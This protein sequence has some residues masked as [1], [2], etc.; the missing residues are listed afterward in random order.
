MDILRKFMKNLKLNKYL[1][2]EKPFSTAYPDLYREVLTG[3]G[4]S[5]L[6]KLYLYIHEIPVPTCPACGS[7][8]K[9]VG[10]WKGYNRFCGAGCSNKFNAAQVATTKLRKYG[11][12]GYNNPEQARKTCLE[13]YGENYETRRRPGP[14]PEERKTRLAATWANKTEEEKKA[15]Q[16]KR[17]RTTRTRYGTDNIMHIPEV[18]TKAQRT[19][20]DR[21]GSPGQY[22]R[23]RSKEGI[24]RKTRETYPEFIGY[25]GTDWICR[26]PHPD[27]DKCTERTYITNPGVHRDRL[28]NQS[29]LCTH[30]QP[31]GTFVEGTAP[32]LFVREI[33]DR[34]G[35][36]HE[37]NRYDLI[38]PLSLDIYMPDH[39][40]AIECNGIYWHS[41]IFKGSKDHYRKWLKCKESDIRLITIWEDWIKR[42]PEIV[43]SL[44]LNRL[45]RTGTSIGARQA[46]VVK[47]DSSTAGAFLEANHIQGATP[48]SVR[49]GLEYK[50][51]LVSLMCFSGRG[52]QWELVRFCNRIGLGVPGAASRLL[53][54]FIREYR[55]AKVISFS[56]NDISDGHLYKV[57]GFK[58]AGV[59]VGYWYVDGT[60]K[61]YHRSTFAKDELI[62]KGLAPTDKTGW[63][64]T[65]IMKNLPYHRIYDTGTVRWE[66]IL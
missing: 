21:Y 64:E 48:S 59:S 65:S 25:A 12:T 49:L 5:W 44:L 30:L 52:G 38:Y 39:R 26:C 57:L 42:K 62:R 19:F 23:Q 36:I 13:R 46:V 54:H 66:L 2:R 31:I 50:G 56:S 51:Q 29:E 20:E 6:E 47:V 17:D 24:E 63:T 11:S 61:R 33:L 53:Q 16:A 10:F 8:V 43:E 45:G 41:D 7:P 3:P 15:I 60:F 32:E 22:L 34:N 40:M 55:P 35:I 18:A 28:R 58:E 1:V 27:C 4:D 14:C 9:F 37:D